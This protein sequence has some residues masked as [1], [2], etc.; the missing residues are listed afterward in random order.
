MYLLNKKTLPIIILLISSIIYFFANNNSYA[1]TNIKDPKQLQLSLSAPND[2][3]IQIFSEPIDAKTLYF[4]DIEEKTH[5]VTDFK[6]KILIVNVWDVWCGYCRKEMPDLTRLNKILNKDNF[7]IINIKSEPRNISKAAKFIS[8]LDKNPLN[9]YYNTYYSLQK[10]LIQN[11]DSFT[12]VGLP[13]AFIVNKNGDAIAMLHG[14]VKWD[15]LS[16]VNFLLL[17]SEIYS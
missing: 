5:S 11:I 8:S 12:A 3:P 6:E 4:N 9:F 15:D 7:E 10:F 1:K 17:V 2:L 14:A 13:Y 16:V